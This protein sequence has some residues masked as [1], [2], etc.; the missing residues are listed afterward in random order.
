MAHPQLVIDKRLSRPRALITPV[1]AAGAFARR[2][3]VLFARS[4]ARR[5]TANKYVRLAVV[6][7]FMTY[8]TAALIGIS[9]EFTFDKPPVHFLNQSNAAR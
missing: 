1:A 6:S 9:F 7:G 8:A 4:G 3:T 2:A 5:I